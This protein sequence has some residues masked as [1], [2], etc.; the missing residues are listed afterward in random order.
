MLDAAAFTDGSCFLLSNELQQ[1]GSPLRDCRSENKQKRHNS[2]GVCEQGFSAVLSEVGGEVLCRVL[3][4]VESC[5]FQKYETIVTG[6]PGVLTW[7]GGAVARDLN[8]LTD[9]RDSKRRTGPDAVETLMKPHSY[10][11][12]RAFFG[13]WSPSHPPVTNHGLL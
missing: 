11:G 7:A 4:A 3:S 1:V 10:F 8:E 9:Y 6:L 13:A 2:Y 12:K 5:C